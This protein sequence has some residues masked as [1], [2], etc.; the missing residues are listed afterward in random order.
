[1]AYCLQGLDDMASPLVVD[2]EELYV[3]LGNVYVAIQRAAQRIARENQLSMSHLQVLLVLNRIRDRR[4]WIYLKELYPH[5]RLTQPAIGRLV[6]YLAYWEY[7][8]IKRDEGD[9]RRLLIRLLPAGKAVLQRFQQV[10]AESLDPHSL[11]LLERS[12][13]R[14]YRL[15]FVPGELPAE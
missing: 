1:M 4:E 5:F 14:L 10:S 9:R 11:S 6:R 12:L 13:Q 7:I 8:Q 3:N 15:K 2:F